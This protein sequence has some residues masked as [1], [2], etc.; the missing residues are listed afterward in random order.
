MRHSL[1]AEYVYF[2]QTKAFWK[3]R[4]SFPNAHNP[5]Q[6][7]IAFQLNGKLMQRCFPEKIKSHIFTTRAEPCMKLQ[8]KLPLKK[9]AH[10]LT[11]LELDYIHPS[12]RIL[13]LF[14]LELTGYQ[15]H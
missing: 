12:S 15:L 1:I 3:L 14:S 5:N 7:K 6:Y 11:P 8:D 13:M 4:A 10:A 2:Q 9:Y